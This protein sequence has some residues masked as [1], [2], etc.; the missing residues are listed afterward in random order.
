MARAGS[1]ICPS[2]LDHND[3]GGGREAAPPP[4]VDLALDTVFHAERMKIALVG[5]VREGSTPRRFVLVGRNGGSTALLEAARLYDFTRA[6][7]DHACREAQDL[8]VRLSCAPDW[9]DFVWRVLVEGPWERPLAVTP[10]W[11][12]EGRVAP[13]HVSY[14]FD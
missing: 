4:S 10:V 7:R 6:G 3:G 1:A 8:L 11:M 14:Y 2:A 5:G 9:L 13:V 12:L